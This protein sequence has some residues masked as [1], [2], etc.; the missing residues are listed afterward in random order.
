MIDSILALASNTCSKQAEFQLSNINFMLC[1]FIEHDVETKYYH[2]AAQY[3]LKIRWMKYMNFYEDFWA[4]SL[5]EKR[6]EV[7]YC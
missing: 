2:R 1:C 5:P 6:T 3:E 4:V 7:E